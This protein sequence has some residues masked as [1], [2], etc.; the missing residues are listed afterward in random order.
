MSL[1]AARA[2]EPAFHPAAGQQVIDLGP[3]LFAVMRSRAEGRGRVLCLHNV[4][5]RPARV[6][7]APPAGLDLLGRHGL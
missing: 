3:G 5:G 1:L 7:A 6:A 4:T 2:G